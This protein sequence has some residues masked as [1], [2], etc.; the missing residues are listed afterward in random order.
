VISSKYWLLNKLSCELD[1]VSLAEG[2][3]ITPARDLL[4]KLQGLSLGVSRIS[5]TGRVIADGVH[6]CVACRPL[7]DRVQV[8]SSQGRG[9]TWEDAVAGALL[10]AAERQ[11]AANHSLTNCLEDV[12]T[13]DL[14]KLRVRYVDPSAFG[15]EPHLNSSRFDW[16]SVLHPMSGETVYVPASTV[17]FPYFERSGQKSPVSP[18]TSGLASGTTPL[19]AFLY[20]LLELIERHEYSEVMADI[21]SAQQINFKDADS[22]ILQIVERLEGSDIAV[23]AVL[24]PKTISYAANT[25]ICF[26][27]DQSGRTRHSVT[28]GIAAHVSTRKALMDAL[29]EVF[30]SHATQMWG[31][32]ED[33]MRVQDSYNRDSAHADLASFRKLRAHLETLPVAAICNNKFFPSTIFCALDKLLN[34]MPEDLQGHTYFKDLS[35][36]KAVPVVRVIV[37]GCRDIRVA[38]K[39]FATRIVRGT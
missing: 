1:H 35:V 9:R 37:P 31:S 11:A 36:H 21:N 17:H 18:N 34:S 5:S 33:L 6:I 8:T 30:Q 19:E 24:A 23:L 29:T 10:E 38:P 16:V 25:V 7:V 32:R 22:E 26:A 12:S 13:V 39:L 27:Q 15:L 14:E 20:G 4:H 2:L 3:R 28:S